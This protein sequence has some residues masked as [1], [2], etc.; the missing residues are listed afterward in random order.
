MTKN[1]I[2]EINNKVIELHEVLEKADNDYTNLTEEYKK[3]TSAIPYTDIFKKYSVNTDSK[4]NAR[5]SVVSLLQDEDSRKNIIDEF[6]KYSEY[7]ESA[8]ILEKMDNAKM[9][10]YHSFMN[11]YNYID[12]VRNKYL[13]KEYME[14]IDYLADKGYLLY[15]NYLPDE[16]IEKLSKSELEKYI[17]DLYSANNFNLI[18]YSYKGYLDLS[19]YDS[20]LQESKV[21]RFRGAVDCLIRGSYDL[22]SMAMFSL[23]ENE[24]TKVSGL[25]SSKTK[26]PEKIK[27]IS[28]KITGLHNEYY[29]NLWDKMETLHGKWFTNTNNQNG[30]ELNRN[31]L[32]HGVFKKLVIKK[33]DC[34]QLFLFYINLKDI[35]YV[36]ETMDFFTDEFSNDLKLFSL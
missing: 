5:K 14:K 33:E 23:I 21:N 26:N 36:I 20:P 15:Y 32:D 11:Y 9:H 16:E 24:Y 13:S 27:E 31:D 2:F 34:I 19:E 17:I 6:H 10:F 12:Q 35:R 8:K 18:Y 7:A 28:R 4:E 1:E 3:K 22:C 30:D 29:S 25:F